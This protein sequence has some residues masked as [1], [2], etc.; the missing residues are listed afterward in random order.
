[1]DM[2]SKRFSR[3]CPPNRELNASFLQA[4]KE[5]QKLE[6]ALETDDKDM[7]LTN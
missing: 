7:E 4:E 6:S 3:I 1:M 5:W 2:L